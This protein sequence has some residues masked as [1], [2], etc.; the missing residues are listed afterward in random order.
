MRRF[1]IA[2]VAVVYEHERDSAEKQERPLW[3][4]YSGDK[5]FTAVADGAFNFTLFNNVN[6][7][8]L[9]TRDRNTRDQGFVFGPTWC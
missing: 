8:L 9:F 3:K 4:S 2:V 5:H 1:F 7:D 6:T